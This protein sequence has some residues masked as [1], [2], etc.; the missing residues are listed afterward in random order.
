MSTEE[1]LDRLEKIVIILVDGLR[2]SA[3][4]ANVYFLIKPLIEKL[5]K[6][7]NRRC[8]AC[9]KTDCPRRYSTEEVTERCVTFNHGNKG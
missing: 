1:R 9:L 5:E 6:V 7:V 2:E 3:K 4:K 8:C